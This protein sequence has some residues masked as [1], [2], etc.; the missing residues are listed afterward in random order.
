MLDVHFIIGVVMFQLRTAFALFFLATGALPALAQ[1][2]FG[3]IT[4]TVTD[5]SGA[6]TPGAKIIVLNEATAAERT[7]NTSDS[8]TYVVTNLPVGIY[9]VR[10][11]LTGFQPSARTGLNVV[12]DARLTADLVL[13]PGAAAETVNVV[14]S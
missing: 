8:G 9:T 5:S 11:E 7:L 12:A 1:T 13:R 6:V 4:G 3:R 14:E 10:V 2:N